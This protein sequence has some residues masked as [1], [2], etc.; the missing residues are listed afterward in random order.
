MPHP[1]LLEL[2]KREAS[3]DLCSRNF[4]H[5]VKASV[6]S[7]LNI[8]SSHEANAWNSDSVSTHITHKNFHLLDGASICFVS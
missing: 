1:D 3:P 2:V 8:N 6:S 5:P 7:R 4:P